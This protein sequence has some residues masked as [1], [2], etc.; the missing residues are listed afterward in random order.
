MNLRQRLPDLRRGANV[1]RAWPGSSHIGWHA[2]AFA[3]RWSKAPGLAGTAARR[4]R[5]HTQHQVIGDTIDCCMLSEAPRQVAGDTLPSRRQ[6]AL[7]KNSG[8]LVLRGPVTEQCHIALDQGAEFLVYARAEG[9]QVA[10]PECG[11]ALRAK[12]D[13]QHARVVR[14]RS[15]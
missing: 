15:E 3:G 12:E 4:I 1:D 10:A 14:P 13:I 2:A 6:W 7:R 11:S 9:E 8:L 5:E